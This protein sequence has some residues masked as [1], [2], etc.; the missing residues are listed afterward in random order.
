MSQ[1]IFPQRMAMRYSSVSKIIEALP[2][3]SILRVFRI[4]NIYNDNVNSPRSETVELGG[5]TLVEF[6]EDEL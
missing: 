1:S 5:R 6:I 3:P 4:K 2:K